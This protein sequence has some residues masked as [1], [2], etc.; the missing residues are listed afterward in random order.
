ML[1][2]EVVIKNTTM[3]ETRNDNSH[4]FIKVYNRV[5]IDKTLDYLEKLIFSEIISYQLQ[6]KVFFK[7]NKS[8]AYEY[9][10]SE[11]TIQKR[12]TNLQPLLY[13]EPFY[14]INPNGG[15]P[16][17]RRKLVVKSLTDYVPQ[18]IL[19]NLNID[20]KSFKTIRE[21]MIWC[22]HTFGGDSLLIANFINSRP[23]I[24]KH[25]GKIL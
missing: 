12:I 9:G 25:L 5:K 23:Y 3:P 14:P 17:K 13:N 18:D 7:T 8:L 2:V 10:C 20:I 22:N 24:E 6:G 19:S 11:N 21:F 16:P 15:R 1:K 4:Q